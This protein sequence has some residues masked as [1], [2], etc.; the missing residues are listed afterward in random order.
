VT[1]SFYFEAKSKHFVCAVRAGL[2]LLHRPEQPCGCPRQLARSLHLLRWST[3]L[4][5]LSLLLLFV[6]TSK[7]ATCIRHT[8]VLCESIRC[9]LSHWYTALE[10]HLNLLHAP[11]S[12]LAYAEPDICKCVAYRPSVDE[13][14]HRAEIGGV[15]YVWRGEEGDHPP[16]EEKRNDRGTRY[17]AAVPSGSCFARH[18]VC[19]RAETEVEGVDDDVANDY[20][21]QCEAVRHRWLADSKASDGEIR[22]PHHCCDEKVGSAFDF[23][24]EDNGKE[25]SDNLQYIG[26]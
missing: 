23:V 22:Y 8:A 17:F 14:K 1:G 20:N 4:N 18:R 24:A 15:V 21:R 12:C 11:P 19:Q 3:G 10:K 9:P 2:G 13:A 7:F 26:D 5:S 25:T 16:G 6:D